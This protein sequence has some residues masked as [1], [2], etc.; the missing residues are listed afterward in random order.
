MDVL[1]RIISASLGGYAVTYAVTAALASLLPVA[2]VEAV[3]IASMPSFLIYLAAIIWVFSASSAAR[4]WLGLVFVAA[5]SA[6]IALWPQA[7]TPP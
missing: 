1:S 4:A 6:A 7:L 2:R 3:F 5:L